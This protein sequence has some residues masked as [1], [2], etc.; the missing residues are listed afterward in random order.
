MVGIGVGWMEEEFVLAGQAFAKRGKRSDEMVEIFR[1]LCSGEMEEYH[2][3]FYDFSPVQMQPVPTQV[4][5]ILVGGH[6]PIALRRAARLDGWI[7]VNYDLPQA[8]EHLGA[9]HAARQ[10]AGRLNHPFESA[11]ALNTEP[12]HDDCRRLEDAGA[13]IL[14]NPPLGIPNAA[15]T[16]LEDKLA[17][18]SG[19]AE[20]LIV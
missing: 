19:Y 10:E 15:T 11:L 13:T 16:P 14:V 1:K 12:S 8:L 4:P 18:L 6:S 7:G 2:G 20:R 9:L 3:E 5:P 17:S